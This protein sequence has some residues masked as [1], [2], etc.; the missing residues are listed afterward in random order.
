MSSEV[1][2]SLVFRE[3][4]VRDPSTPLGMTERAVVKLPRI[5]RRNY[6]WF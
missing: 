6:R 4:I 3:I 5:F 2:T 1:E